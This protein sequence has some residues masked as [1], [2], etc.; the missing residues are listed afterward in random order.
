MS[1]ISNLC[2]AFGLTDPDPAPVSHTVESDD[3][4]TPLARVRRADL[5]ELRDGYGCA[6]TVASFD[7][8]KERRVDCAIANSGF[9]VTYGMHR[10][11][12]VH[13][14]ICQPSLHL[15][16]DFLKKGVSIPLRVGFG[17]RTCSLSI[18]RC[19]LPK[20]C[21]PAFNHIFNN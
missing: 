21:G 15:R 14:A 4:R 11:L 9:A 18:A 6:E 20:R 8:E 3:R 16:W 5:C 7:E 2:L 12:R 13:E 10:R 17:V 19:T 1:I